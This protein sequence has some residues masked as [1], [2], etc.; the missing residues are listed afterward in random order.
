MKNHIGAV[1]LFAAFSLAGVSSVHAA[2]AVVYK[3]PTCGCCSGWEAHLRDHGFDV[4]SHNVSDVAAYKARLGLPVTL[5]SCHTAVIDGYVV[6]G[7]VPA[8]DIERLL[9]ERPDVAGLAV[10]GMPSGSP[11]MSGPAQRY[12]VISFA[13]D[14]KQ[15]VFARH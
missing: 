3:S 15:R 1:I 9:E 12:N 7:H 10:P 13:A 11:G 4:Q 2:D 14:G 6:E 5:G 8:R